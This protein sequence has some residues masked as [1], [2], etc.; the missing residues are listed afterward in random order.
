MTFH[1]DPIAGRTAEIIETV[2]Q[3]AEVQGVPQLDYAFRL[4][5]EE[6]VVNVQNYS[7]SSDITIDVERD[8]HLLR[9]RFRDHGLPFNPLEYETPDLTLDADKR[10]VGGLGIFLV[11][12]LMD[13]VSYRYDNENILTVEKAIY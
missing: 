8:D 1:F 9:L 11:K 13:K 3:S 10:K 7:T 12:E 4:V 2:M 5:T 6:L